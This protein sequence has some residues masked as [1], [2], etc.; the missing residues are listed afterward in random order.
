[1]DPFKSRRNIGQV[2]K[3]G[4]GRE[5][6]GSFKGLCTE[7]KQSASVL[8]LNWRVS[9][10]LSLFRRSN[11]GSDLRGNGG[12]ICFRAEAWKATAWDTPTFWR[13]GDREAARDCRSN[14]ERAN[15]AIV[16]S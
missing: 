12:R 7:S 14:D 16:T 6:T 11:R 5:H 9:R 2:R 13:R 4:N 1:M 15:I 10:S 3:F 8:I